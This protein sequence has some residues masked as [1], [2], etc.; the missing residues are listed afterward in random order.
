[1]QA[2]ARTCM[3]HGKS[4]INPPLSL[5]H[6]APFLL[7]SRARIPL[8]LPS[9]PDGLLLT[10]TWWIGLCGALLRWCGGGTATLHGAVGPLGGGASS[11]SGGPPSIR[12]RA[13]LEPAAE[14]P[15]SGAGAGLPRSDCGAAPR[16]E[17][18]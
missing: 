16:L 4:V 15:A 5:Y 8:S 12:R 18:E 6:G 10:P 1:V 3:H 2:A 17:A 7:S 11:G 9:L 13:S 14:D